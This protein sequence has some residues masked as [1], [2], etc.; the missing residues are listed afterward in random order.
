M[1]PDEMNPIALAFYGD[2]VYEQRV[3]EVLVRQGIGK[4]DRLHKEAVK[5]VCATYQAAA[6]RK[7]EPLLT[8]KEAD[9]F[10][11]GRNS[12]SVKAPKNADVLNYRLATGLEA[13]LGWLALTEQ[14]E[15][16]EVLLSDI[17]TETVSGEK[18]ETL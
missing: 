8:E 12:S 14:I 18:E 3:R 1:K 6:A 7:I 11:R 13:L 2:A 17:L 15:R 5:R 10:R 4:P 9:I 16:M